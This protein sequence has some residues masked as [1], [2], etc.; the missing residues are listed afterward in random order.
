[1]TVSGRVFTFTLV[2]YFSRVYNFR[3]TVVSFTPLKMSHYH[4]SASV[5]NSQLVWFLSLVD[6]PYLNLQDS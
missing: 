6:R 1:M 3:S 2:S 4:L 5:G